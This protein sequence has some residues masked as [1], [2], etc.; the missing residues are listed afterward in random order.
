[1]EE[2]GDFKTTKFDFKM[3]FFRHTF[4]LEIHQIL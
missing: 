4:Q 3:L 1:M 2:Q